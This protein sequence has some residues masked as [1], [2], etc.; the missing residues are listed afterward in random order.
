MDKGKPSATIDEI[1]SN[2]VSATAFYWISAIRSD[3]ERIT[4]AD[5]KKALQKDQ[6]RN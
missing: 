5:V 2:G 4:I 3:G 6:I 1:P